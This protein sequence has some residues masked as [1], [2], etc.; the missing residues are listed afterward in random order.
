M[1]F[2]HRLFNL[3]RPFLPKRLKS[4]WARSPDSPRICLVAATRLSEQDFWRHSHL[5]R[6]A[7]PPLVSKDLTLRIAFENKTGLPTLYNSAIRESDAD[8][9]VFL[10]DDVWLDDVKFEEKIKDALLCFDIVG[11]AGNLK[12]PPKQPSWFFKSFDEKSGFIKE[13]PKNLSGAIHH[14]APA[15]S[16]LSTFGPS[17]KSCK[18][19]D[20]VFIAANRKTLIEMGVS[21]DTRFNFDF[22]DLDFC[23][24]ALKQG[25]K[26]GTWP[27][28]LIHKSA[29]N[30]GS[31]KWK[32]SLSTYLEKWW[33]V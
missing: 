15:A 32:A 23:Q 19:I 8:I 10:H 6:S 9:L 13:N 5:G 27:I 33:N 16:Q 21:F 30:F 25:L 4:P 20:G 29:G 14:G 17:P 26:I 24:T 11:V 2:R 1:S 18:L 3:L 7:K 22:Y 12:N 31:E 28:K